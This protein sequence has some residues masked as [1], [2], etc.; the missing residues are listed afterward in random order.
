MVFSSLLFLCIFLPI[1][2]LLYYASK[3]LT[4]KNVILVIASLLFYAWGEPIYVLALIFSSLVDYT[5]GRVS[6]NHFGT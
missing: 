1:V 5:V 2:L 6:H 4:Y 3:N